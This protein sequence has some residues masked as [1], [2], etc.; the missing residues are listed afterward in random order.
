MASTFWRFLASLHLSVAGQILKIQRT[1]RQRVWEAAHVTL[2]EV[3]LDTDTTVHTRFGQQMGTR[4]AYNP[5]NRGKKSHQPILTFLAETREYVGG[6]LRN[7]DRPT[8]HR[9][10]LG[11]YLSADKHRLV[12]R[13]SPADRPPSGKRMVA[14][15]ETVQTI[16]ARADSG[17]YC[18]EAIQAYDQKG[19][20]FIVSARKTSRLLEVLRAARWTRSPRTDAD[21]QCEFRYQPEGWAQAYRF[22]ARRYKKEP[23]GTRGYSGDGG[24]A[25]NAQV[26]GSNNMTCGREREPLPHRQQS[27]PENIQG[28]NHH[29]GGRHG[30]RSQHRRRG[31]PATSALLSF[32]TDVALDAG[33]NLYIAD[34]G[35]NRIGRVPW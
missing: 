16:R 2:R 18:W 24:A 12:Q 33:G 9:H 26:A 1:L 28:W 15:P 35:V 4:K 3:T 25:L 21:G 20:Q 22:L 23:N 5:K 32:P 31:G 11:L 13:P 27:H 17:F 29:H 7:G 14:L 34:T 10:L 19:C 6:E 30:F 8:D